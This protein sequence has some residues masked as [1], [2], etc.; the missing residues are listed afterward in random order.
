MIMGCSGL[1]ASLILHRVNAML[2]LRG[3]TMKKFMVR[4]GLAGVALALAAPS[5]AAIRYDFTAF[6]SFPNAYFEFGA[7]PEIVTGSFSVITPTYINSAR[8]IAPGALTAF[9]ANGSLTGA[10]TAGP[11]IFQPSGGNEDS[12]IFGFV[13]GP[14]NFQA[15]AA[16]YFADGAF[17]APGTYD[18]V[19]FGQDQ[20]GRLVVTN[21]GGPGVPEP[22]SWAMLI[23]GFG[24]MGAVQRRRRLAAA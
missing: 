8:S 2:S 14:F 10:L 23:A 16:Y 13:G 7:P 22:A 5:Q 19:L 3:V 20:A 17:S 9:S 1:S 11:Q 21:L 6:S 15:S 4:A 12:I 18:T 24:L